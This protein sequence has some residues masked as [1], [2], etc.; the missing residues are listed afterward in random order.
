MNWCLMIYQCKS[1]IKV[2]RGDID[3]LKDLELISKIAHS[4]NDV[5]LVRNKQGQELALKELILKSDN[6]L[7]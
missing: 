6:D 2:L 1:E 3:T 4:N 5:Y 7:Q